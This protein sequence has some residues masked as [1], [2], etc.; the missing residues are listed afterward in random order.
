[1]AFD[2]KKTSRITL[3]TKIII[4]LL[5][6]PPKIVIIHSRYFLLIT[7]IL[8]VLGIRILFYCHAA[9][10]KRNFSFKFFKC[11]GYIAVSNASKR[12]LTASGI[13]QDKIKVIYNPLLIT[14][15][16][17]LVHPAYKK[18]AAISIGRLA[19]WKGFHKVIYYLQDFT[20]S[21]HYSIIGEGDFKQKLL[22]HAGNVAKSV[23]IHFLG[24]HSTPYKLT[25][26]I[27]IVIIPSLEEGFG[28]V[29][30]EAIYNGRIILYSDIDA[31]REICGSDPLSIP[32]DIH[33]PASFLSGLK[34]ALS[35]VSETQDQERIKSRSRAISSKYN[36][37]AFKRRYESIVDEQT[38]SK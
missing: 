11:H 13:S 14:D 6:S 28:L 15:P 12:M 31:L 19:P 21:F 3:C 23:Q 18:S 1:M 34:Q 32:F 24:Q 4:A 16:P 2:S 38:A 30:I 20:S 17:A 9:Y 26:D 27:P 10:T 5:K 37:S 7:P 33:S 25:S 8:R 22:E 36:L 29:G 35:I